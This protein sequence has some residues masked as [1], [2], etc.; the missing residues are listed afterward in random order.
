MRLKQGFPL[1]IAILFGLLT[2]LGLLFNN[3]VISNLIL[4]WAG[5]LAVVA[6]LLGI[7]NLYAV[8]G[9]RLVKKQN[10]YSGVLLLSMTLVFALALT[11][12]SGRTTGG[13]DQLFQWIQAPLEAALASLLAFFLLFAGFQLL[14]RQRSWW[15]VLFLITAV[16]ILLINII[17]TATFLPAEL[18]APVMLLRGIV[19][20]IIVVSGVRGLLI[21]I[22]LATTVLAIRVLIGMERPYNE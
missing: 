20:D 16:L 11:D 18:T 7:L 5:L 21:G 15:S 12:G 13:V 10:I 3:A 14:K 6:L 22:A 17:L 8:H 2:L 1:F 19:N 4:Q 9:Q